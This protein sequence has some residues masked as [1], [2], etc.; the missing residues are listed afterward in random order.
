MMIT[1]KIIITK[2]TT[3]EYYEDNK[4]VD[5][6]NEDDTYNINHQSKEEHHTTD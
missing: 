2:N 3:Y 5:I 4:D 1:M 6:S